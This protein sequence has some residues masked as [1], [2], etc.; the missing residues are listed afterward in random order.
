LHV[1]FGNSFGSNFTS[2]GFIVGITF[3]FMNATLSSYSSLSKSKS[4]AALAAAALPAASLPA[5]RDASA[6][7]GVAATA[8]SAAASATTAVGAGGGDGFSSCVAFE[9][10][11][12]NARATAR[13]SILLR[14]IACRARTRKLR[15]ERQ[16]TEFCAR[17][18]CTSWIDV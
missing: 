2:R 1:T 14:S 7:S 4:L 9:Q 5:S 3:C 17:A 11:I 18:A 16:L 8:V 6:A 12:T 13:R 10:P 15:R